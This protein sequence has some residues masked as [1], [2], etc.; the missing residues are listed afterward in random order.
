MKI[1]LLNERLE[2]ASATS[3]SLDLARSLLARGHQVEVATHGGELVGSF[4]DS[5]VTTWLVRSNVFAFRRL[6]AYLEDSSPDL[7]HVQSLRSLPFA[8]RLISRLGRPLVVTV[9]N[10]PRTQTPRLSGP[11]LRGCIATGESIR[12][13]LVGRHGLPAESV[14]V[15]PRCI[16]VDA[17]SSNSGDLWRGPEHRLPVVAVIG[18]L[19][20]EKG[21]RFLVEAARR[22]I[23]AGVEAHFAIVGEGPEESA[24][25]RQVR[26]LQLERHVTFA[27]HLREPAELYAAID[28]LVLPTL[29]R[30]TAVSAVEALA[31]ERPVIA[32]AVGE[33]LEVVRDGDTGITVPE[34]DAAALAEGITGL[35]ADPDALRAMGERGRRFVEERFALPQMAAAT[36]SFYEEC[37]VQHRR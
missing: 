33:L 34:G 28:L 11:L 15:I 3:Y 37:L 32:S 22:V 6:I 27:P 5:G 2:F 26:E 14:R 10:R 18:K 35:L 7:V 12:A 1:L 31:M 19:R 21:H 20:P 30:G 23:D 4:E 9:H 8:Q 25:R 29:R 16:D 13:A 17:F 36:E 24:L